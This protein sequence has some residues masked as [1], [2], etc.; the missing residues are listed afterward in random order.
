M[1]L[2]PQSFDLVQHVDTVLTAAMDGEK[3]EWVTQ[4]WVADG[5]ELPATATFECAVVP[6][7]LPLLMPG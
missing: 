1:L 6:D 7:G 5:E 4:I 2:D 3:S